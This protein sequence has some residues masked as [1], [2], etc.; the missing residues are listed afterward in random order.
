MQEKG[1]CILL[2]NRTV[3]SLN[4]CVKTKGL[5]NGPHADKGGPLP[6]VVYCTFKYIS[7]VHEG[8]L[9]LSD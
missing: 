4:F 5:K 6:G 2:E 1:N 7:V 3:G 8:L 9:Y